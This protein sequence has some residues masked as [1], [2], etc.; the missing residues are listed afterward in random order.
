[1]FEFKTYVL[2]KKLNFVLITALVFL[3]SEPVYA[4]DPF[5]IAAAISVGVNAVSSLTDGV[6]ELGDATSAFSELY[7]E[8]NP[9]AEVSKESQAL[10]QQIQET[11]ALAREAGYT[12]DQI[13]SLLQTDHE[14]VKKLSSI[15]KRMTKAVQVSKQVSRMFSK[16]EKKA[17]VAEV[18]AAQTEREILKAQYQM[19]AQARIA[20]LEPKKEELKN[21]IERKKFLESKEREVQKKGG[22]KWGKIGVYSFPDLNLS[23]R[24]ALSISEVLKKALMI[25]IFPIFLLRR[26][27]IG[28]VFGGEEQYHKLL[29]DTVLCA[30]WLL[31][32]P[33][34]IPLISETTSLLAARVAESHFISSPPPFVLENR[35]S[36]ATPAAERRI[37][38]FPSSSEKDS[39]Q[40][41]SALGDSSSLSGRVSE[42]RI[43]QPS[44]G[45][46][47]QGIYDSIAWIFQNVKLLAFGICEFVFNLGLAVLIVFMPLIIFSST[48]LQFSIGV[49]SYLSM[50]IALS[51]WPLFWN[52]IGLL[53]IRMWDQSEL[54]SL[55]SLSSVILALAQFLA[56]FFGYK[57]MQG[58]GALESLGSTAMSIVNA[59]GKALAS[60]QKLVQ[61]PQGNPTALSRAAQ[62]LVK[63]STYAA[64]QAVQR[65]YSAYQR[66]KEEAGSRD[67]TRNSIVSQGLRG[68]VSNQAKTAPVYRLGGPMSN[69]KTASS[70]VLEGLKPAQRIRGS[71]EERKFL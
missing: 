61:T 69:L 9:D 11:E 17:Q 53:A 58:H 50:Y 1:M 54:A 26:V 47:W 28:V 36:L 24:E 6:G 19:I 45:F 4:F 51:L 39:S 40:S 15:L 29:R 68:F 38:G 59:P 42:S 56:P 12:A 62:G 63:G 16:L 41:F 13:Q 70:R 34:I 43:S 33:Q 67:S 5:S 27:R 46:G 48:M 14:D 30:V 10:I 2:K 20:R 60:A 21:K 35:P 37:I 44:L 32:L 65:G 66:G 25:L 8:L 57:F 7:G 49:K 3:C 18:E 64:T 31:V 23:F 22:L 55:S 71:K 52:V